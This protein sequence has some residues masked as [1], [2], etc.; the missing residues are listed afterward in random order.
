MLRLLTLGGLT[1]RREGLPL[2]GV[3]PQALAILTRIA[4]AG[5]RGISRQKVAGCFWAERDE[6]HARHS[7]SQ[8]LYEL[9]LAAGGA[10]LVVGRD[11][12]RVDP[13]VVSCDARDFEAALVAGH[14][15]LASTLHAGPF[16]DGIYL[17]GA[18]EFERWSETQRRRLVQELAR[19]LRAASSSAIDTCDHG[20][21][22][23]WLHRLADLDPLD[24]ATALDLVRV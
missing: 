14:L 16:L 20:T 13:A 18:D 22:I 11:V 4:V 3:T 8:A 1:L 9:R 15:E 12:L 10:T 24:F 19:G 21:A 6:R 23:R 2:P 17:T 7:L 5:D